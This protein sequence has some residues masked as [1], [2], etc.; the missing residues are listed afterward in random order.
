MIIDWCKIIES[1]R[2]HTMKVGMLW[3]F[4]FLGSTK[5]T[6]GTDNARCEEPSAIPS[7]HH[8]LTKWTKLN[9]QCINFM[10][11]QCTHI[12]PYFV[13][14]RTEIA[15]SMHHILC[16]HYTDTGPHLGIKKNFLHC[17]C[18][19]IAQYVTHSQERNEPQCI[20]Q[21]SNFT[22]YI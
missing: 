22:S 11:H 5:K 7:L 17:L 6:N 8:I 16:N 19:N 3:T 1:I 9:C 4:R 12:P 2:E 10:D 15:P 21:C 14:K 20:R 13:K 18:T